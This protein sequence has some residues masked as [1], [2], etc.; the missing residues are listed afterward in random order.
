MLRKK[1]VWFSKIK[2]I[3]LNYLSSTLFD[4]IYFVPFVIIKQ[5]T[6]LW[7]AGDRF[8]NSPRLDITYGQHY[9]LVYDLGSQIHVVISC[10]NK[11]SFQ[12]ARIELK[13]QLCLFAHLHL[14][15]KFYFTRILTA[16]L[17]HRTSCFQPNLKKLFVQ[18]NIKQIPKI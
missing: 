11:V 2:K 12:L 3:S 4:Q 14:W 10:T 9:I 13:L 5:G 8:Q 7:F 18:R 6:R 16:Q 17:P 1:V 15:H